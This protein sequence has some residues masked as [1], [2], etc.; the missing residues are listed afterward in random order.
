MK[1][2]KIY[3]RM[4]ENEKKKDIYSRKELNQPQTQIFVCEILW[5]LHFPQSST[6]KD[7]SQVIGVW[8]GREGQS[9][10]IHRNVSIGLYK[11]DKWGLVVKVQQRHPNLHLIFEAFFP[12]N[13]F[14]GFYW[15]WW[16]ILSL[17]L[18]GHLKALIFILPP[19][20][21][22]FDPNFKRVFHCSVL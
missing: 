9:N 19:S 21:H 1:R 20:H 18:A 4:I 14:K 13:C 12:T 11:S 5:N 8:W 6:S 16:A 15:K 22:G 3:Q 17:G 7:N 2:K 10:L